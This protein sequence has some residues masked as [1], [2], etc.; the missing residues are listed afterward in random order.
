MEALKRK[1]QSNLIF[2]GV[3][4]ILFGMW[5]FIKM[6]VYVCVDDP[7]GFKQE[8]ETEVGVIFFLVI[9]GADAII[10]LFIGLSAIK[11]GR[12]Q[13]KSIA[14]IVWIILYFLFSILLGNSVYFIPPY[15]HNAGGSIFASVLVDFSSAVAIFSI[16]ISSIKLR[17]IKRKS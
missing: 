12:G 5:T 15:N 7:F 16:I 9:F 10:R 11:E 13:T 2:G 3:A 4:F 1:Y 6:V 8:L 17:K 14:Y